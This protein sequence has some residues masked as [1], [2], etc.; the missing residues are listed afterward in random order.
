MVKGVRFAKVKD[1]GDPVV[2]AKKYSDDGEDELVFLDISASQQGRE[3]IKNI[4][5]RV[6]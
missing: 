2:L 4:V 1:A 5:R 6:A 3:N